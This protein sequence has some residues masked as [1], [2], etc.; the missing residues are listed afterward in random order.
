VTGGR[1]DA[2]SRITSSCR[3]SPVTRHPSAFTL[4]EIMIVVAIIGLIAVNSH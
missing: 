2:R 1:K 3:L 4:I